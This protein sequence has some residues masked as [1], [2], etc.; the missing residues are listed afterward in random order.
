ML[1]RS[2][3]LL[4][5]GIEWT[6]HSWMMHCER[7]SQINS[8]RIAESFLSPMD[9]SGERKNKKNFDF[10]LGYLENKTLYALFFFYP[11]G[12]SVVP[13]TPGVVSCRPVK[14]WIAPHGPLLNTPG[15]GWSP[16]PAAL[17]QSAQQ[18]RI[19]ST[20]SACSSKALD[21]KKR[22]GSSGLECTVQGQ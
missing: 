20:A 13:L 12:V 10:G 7:S 9:T 3:S 18:M 4:L 22:E 19:W 6:R 16:H 8:P 15:P 11:A 17:I 5:A 2:S 14:E 21:L 1:Y